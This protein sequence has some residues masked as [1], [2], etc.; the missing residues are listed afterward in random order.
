MLRNTVKRLM[1]YTFKP[2]KQTSSF[3]P[4]VWLEFS[5][6]AI[7]YNSV[8]LGQGFPNFEPPKFVKD[9]MIKTIEV[10]GFNQ[11]TRSPGH[12]RLVKALSSVYSP[13]FGRE[14]NA[15]T[16]IMVGVGAS[17]SLFAAISSI[18]N[19]G[20]EVILIEPF[21]DI[22][23]G[24]ILMAGGIPK[25][26]TLKEDESVERS[27]EHKKRSSKDWKI[28]KEELAAAFSDKTK[29]IILNN[30]HNPVGKVYSKEELQEIADVVVKHGPNTTVIS[31][32][33]YEWMTFDGVEHHRFATLPGMWERTVTIG[34]AGKTFSITGW[35]VGWCIG[36][37]NIIGAIANTHQYI[38]FS[39]PTPTQEA[40][41]IALEQPNIK[42][43][44]KELATMYQNKRDTLLN[45]L[46]LAGL[47]PVVPEGTYFIMGDTSSI[48]LE[49]NQGKD[50]SITGMGLHLRDWNIAR[51]L[52]TEY[53][54]T[55]IPP[56][57]FYCDDHQ[58]IPENFVR[59]TFCKDDLTLQK[60]HDN[61]LKLKK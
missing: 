55:T 52:T 22:Y 30:P 39:V 5:P 32:E 31:D 54:I 29:L 42:D 6:L 19:E 1:T 61:L 57:A 24:P 4:S 53:G 9:A 28:N 44:F 21:F 14:L 36:P 58:K 37:S 20:D 48:K 41:A 3:G 26:V 18:V 49:G 56:S 47:D 23:I 50:T 40:V 10:G 12:L 38:P 7:K 11:Y 8:N 35:K 45:S 2:S 51:Y 17:E 60:A 25:F 33:V 34:S 15:M 13:Y 27:S 46:T 59:F 16:E 43:Y